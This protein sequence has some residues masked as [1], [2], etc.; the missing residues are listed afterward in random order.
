MLRRSRELASLIA[1]HPRSLARLAAYL[2]RADGRG[3]ARVM[4]DLLPERAIRVL[5]CSLLAREPI[6]I[7]C[8]RAG[9]NWTVDL[10]DEI[11]E[12]IYVDGRYAPQEID[13]VLAW[14]DGRAGSTI[15]EVGANAGTTSL[16]LAIAGYD[17]VAI[18][19]V[20]ATFA[21]LSH[22]VE[23]NGYGSRVRCVNCAIST[24]RGQVQMWVTRGSG[25][26]E[27]AVEAHGP[28]FSDIVTDPFHGP[29]FDETKVQMTVRS[30]RLDHLLREENVEVADV[31]LVW[32]DAQGSE[33]YVIETGAQLWAAGTPLYLEVEPF[34]IDRHGGLDAFIAQVEGSFG[35][36]LSRD[37]LV[38]GEEPED[39]SGF[40]TLV[41]GVAGTGF[42][43]ALLMQ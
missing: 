31:A 23:R 16:P 17:V 4:A 20:P 30:D 18:E 29:T 40:R 3:L 26:S 43:D 36:F 19:P 33:P 34:L 42:T 11:G 32:C 38:R 22:N 14:L 8:D 9:V 6:V 1:R 27:L 10:G 21:M 13:A 35:R 37:R 39:I 2:T 7:A 25:L 24:T 28:G 5:V 12:A 15:V 41:S